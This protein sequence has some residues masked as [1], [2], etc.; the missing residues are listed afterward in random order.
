M[1]TKK[2]KQVDPLCDTVVYCGPSIPGVANRFT[3]Y[4]GGIPSQ[5]QSKVEEIPVLRGLLVKLEDFPEARKAL[6]DGCGYIDQLY[7]VVQKKL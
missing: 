1:T 6:S 2:E 7:R 4:R 5:L 3:F